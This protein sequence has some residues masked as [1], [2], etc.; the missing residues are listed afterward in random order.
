MPVHSYK[1]ALREHFSARPHCF[2]LI[3]LIV[4]LL[5][6]FTKYIIKSCLA[7]TDVIRVF[8]LFNIVYVEN[9]GSAFGMFRSLGNLFFI[10]VA[11]LAIIFVAALI[12]REQHG[13]WGLSL[14]LGGAA[15]NL[16]D[17]LVRGYVV[18]F[19]DVYVGN[20]HWPAF[21][22]ADSALTIGIAILLF[23]AFSPD[24]QSPPDN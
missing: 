21:N 14:V 16:A 17:R 6:Q 12:V 9:V 2:F 15:G 19:L 10:I 20:H 1:K 11:F 24:K 4:L 3:S 23:T 8:P 13:R 22:V 5:D 18:D 7:P